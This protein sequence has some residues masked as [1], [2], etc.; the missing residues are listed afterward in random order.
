M[1]WARTGVRYGPSLCRRRRRLLLRRFRRRRL[2]RLIRRPGLERLPGLNGR[3]RLLSLGL[4]GLV[5]LAR[6]TGRHLPRLRLSLWHLERLPRP[7][8]PR[9]LRRRGVLPPLRSPR[10]LRIRLPTGL[11]LLPGLRLRLLRSVRLL[12]LRLRLRRLPRIGRLPRLT[13]CLG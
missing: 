9:P 11:G 10:L 5:G 7:R 13:P 1:D 12:G 6:L 8:R 2:R 4:T 3:R